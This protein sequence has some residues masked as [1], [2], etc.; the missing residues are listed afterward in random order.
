MQEYR[1]LDFSLIVVI[2]KHTKGI[3]EYMEEQF[4]IS[5]FIKHKDK[6]FI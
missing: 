5:P 4:I 6:G 3:Y 2:F 1:I